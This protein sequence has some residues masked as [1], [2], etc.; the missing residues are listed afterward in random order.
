MKKQFQD[1]T[2]EFPLELQT[3]LDVGLT[4]GYSEHPSFWFKAVVPEEKA[5]NY[6]GKITEDTLVEV[7]Y[8]NKK[9]Q[10]TRVLFSG[11]AANAKVKHVGGYYVLYVKALAH[12]ANLDIEKK[13]R[14][15]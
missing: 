9:K 2:I 8:V 4:C 14:S 3:I 10:K 11:Y 1:L 15:K 12:T 7:T 6:I 13:S 5:K